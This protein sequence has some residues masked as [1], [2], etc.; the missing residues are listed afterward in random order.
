MRRSKAARALFPPNQ[1]EIQQ[2][3]LGELMAIASAH[4]VRAIVDD[5]EDRTQVCALLIAHFHPKPVVP[6][7]TELEKMGLTGLLELTNKL[8]IDTKTRGFAMLSYAVPMAPFSAPPPPA[9]FCR[10]RGA[11]PLLQDGTLE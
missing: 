9:C 7:V 3:T 5:A 8:G 2:S 1:A 4:G 11:I 6:P 10:R